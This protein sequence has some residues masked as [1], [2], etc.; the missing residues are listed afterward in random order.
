MSRAALVVRAQ[1]AAEAGMVDACTIRRKTGKATDD[2]S[3]VVTPTWVSLYAGKCRVQ[4]SRPQ[5]E[6][7]DAG[8]DYQLQLRLILQLP[9]SVTGLEVGD[10]VT[11]TAS[12]DP[13]MVGRVFLTRDLFHKTD[14]SARRIGVTEGTD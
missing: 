5:S 12:Q 10:Q 1:A 7:Y 6:Q 14:A 13:D 9:M 8:E 11:I 2:F 4:H 3:G